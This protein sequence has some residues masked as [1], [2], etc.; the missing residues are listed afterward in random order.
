VQLSILCLLAATAPLRIG[1]DLQ[2]FVDEYLIESLR[3][4]TLKMH[5]PRS[6]GKAIAFDQPWEGNVSAYITIF[7][8]GDKVR[9]YYRGASD[10]AYSSGAGHVPKHSE[11]TCYAESP[12]GLAWSKPKLGLH[13]FNG[14]EAN[15]I[16]WTGAGAENFSPFKDANPR[17]PA[18]QRYKALAGSKGLIAYQSADA[19]RWT[20][21]REEPVITDGAFD[22]LN[23]AFW[24]SRRECYV[25]VYREFVQGVRT[26]KCATS[27]DFLSWTPGKLAD[28][29]R[30]PAEHLYTNAAQPYFRAPQIYLAFPKRFVPGRKPFDDVPMPGVSEAVFM[31]SRDGVQ[32]DRRFLEAFVRPGRDRHDWVHRTHMTATGIV[33]TAPDE[34]SIWV[35]RHYNFPDA[36][37]ERMT[38]RLDGFVSLHAGYHGGEALTKPLLL[39]GDQ[40][41]FN[42]ATSAAGSIRF[43]IQDLNGHP[44]P[45]LAVDDTKMLYGD[46][47]EE[48]VRL[49]R[50][51]PAPGRAMADQPVRIRFVLKDAD[52]YSFRVLK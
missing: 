13:E 6:A 49:R 23:V 25:A 45:G 28:Y 10:P 3:G 39:E 48:V 31:S 18:S 19:I 40:I 46:Q 36:W 27:R 29:G 8:D 20:K 1:S 34:L 52:L 32:W 14:S 22:S 17:A 12:D 38:L 15:N 11:V 35:S 26:L 16:V 37:L 4:A 5:E 41:A 2:L 44:L 50:S 43:E 7:R 9:M 42:Y 30:A 21:I 47:I 24:D 51:N 33:Q